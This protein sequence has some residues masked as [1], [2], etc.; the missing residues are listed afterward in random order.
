M[1]VIEGVRKAWGKPLFVRISATDWAEGSEQDENG[2]W[3]YWGLEQSKI[4][5]G[6]MQ[7]LGVDLVDVSSG[8]NYVKQA[9]PVGPGYQVRTQPLFAT[10]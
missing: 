9:I 5:V 3:R 1:K 7:K 6:E 4:Y 2:E 10:S 8:G